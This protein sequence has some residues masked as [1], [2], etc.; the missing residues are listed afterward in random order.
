MHEVNEKCLG[1][2][3]AK[4]FCSILGPLV[5][6]AVMALRMRN[7]LE[8]FLIFGAPFNYTSGS[9]GLVILF[10]RVQR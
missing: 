3:V 10:Q 2:V 6:W 1:A 9:L 4:S 5:C 7:S 8:L